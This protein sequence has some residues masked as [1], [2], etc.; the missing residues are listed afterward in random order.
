MACCVTQRPLVYYTFG[1]TDLR[2]DL[3]S[4]HAYLSENKVTV[5]KQFTV[6][7]CGTMEKPNLY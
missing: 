1:D 5:G 3:S 2:D 6:E 7:N 4:M